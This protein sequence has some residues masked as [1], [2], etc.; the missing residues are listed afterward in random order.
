MDRSG[1][2]EKEYELM[3]DDKLRMTKQR[4]IILEILRQTDCHPTADWVFEKARQFLPDISLGT[5]Y[6]N[7]QFLVRKKKLQE[8]IDGSRFSR[9]DGRT[10]THYHF[11]CSRCG[12][13]IDVE[14]PVIASLYEQVKD[15]IPGKVENHRLE[16]Q[17]VCRD[18]LAQNKDSD[19]QPSE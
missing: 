16:F 6:R 7:L 12:A 1:F 8:F 3:V 11:L 5:V 18:C 2:G 17:G 4:R 15:F 14:L 9:F 13:V 10:D 19:D